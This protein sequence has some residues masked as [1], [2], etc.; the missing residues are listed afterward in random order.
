LPLIEQVADVSIEA[1]AVVD[2]V[3]LIVLPG[4]SDLCCVRAALPEADGLAAE[5]ADVLL[6]PHGRE[7]RA[8]AAERAR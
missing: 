4:V 7:S 6:G 5:P 3:G 2:I 8:G 1:A